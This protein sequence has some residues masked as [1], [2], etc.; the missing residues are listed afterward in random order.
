M[1]SCEWGA[2]PRALSL[3]LLR[4]RLL[5]RLVDRDVLAMGQWRAAVGEHERVEFDEAMTFLLVVAGDACTCRQLIAAC[6]GAEKLHPAADMNPGAEDG[7]VDQH[8]V[9]HPLQQ[10]GM[11]E[12]F[13]PIERIALA[14]VGQ[15]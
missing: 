12:P 8:L 10:A 13:T 15:I 4:R 3:I 11:A 1:T 2:A 6:R 7:V 9:H 14:H 5:A